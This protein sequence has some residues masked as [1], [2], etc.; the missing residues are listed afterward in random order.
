MEGI[1][2]V[3]P[4]VLITKAGDFSA[5]AGEVKGIHDQMLS[6]IQSLNSTWTGEAASSYASKFKALEASMNRINAMIMEHSRDL[7]EMAEEY[8]RT[9][10]QVQNII[11]ELP[12]SSLD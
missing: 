6:R 10:S 2:K 7:Q 11:G 9:E 4:D 12:A 1:L 5:K 3:T 8:N